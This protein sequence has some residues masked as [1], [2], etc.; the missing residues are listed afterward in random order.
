MFLD[1]DVAFIAPDG[2]TTVYKHSYN[3]DIPCCKTYS[4][5]LFQ[6]NAGLHFHFAWENSLS[7]KFHFVLKM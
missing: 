6:F 4:L 2:Y 5:Y 3:C 1:F 7:Q